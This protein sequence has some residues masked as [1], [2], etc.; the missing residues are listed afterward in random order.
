M[1]HTDV[2]LP[3]IPVQQLFVKPGQTLT[4]WLCSATPDGFSKQQVELRVT[5]KGVGQ[6]YTDGSV[7]L[8]GFS[9]WRTNE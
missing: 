6:I 4:V 9:A 5:P 3:D 1:D 2:T 8:R 7:E